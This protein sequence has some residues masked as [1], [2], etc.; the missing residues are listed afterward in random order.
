MSQRLKTVN[1]DAI[2]LVHRDISGEYD[3]GVVYGKFIS[4]NHGYSHG[5]W[6]KKGKAL[7][8]YGLEDESLL[9]MFCLVNFDEDIFNSVPVCEE[10]ENGKD[11]F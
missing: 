8:I 5:F 10:E 11:E 1:G 2:I 4:A 6:D 7:A 3:G 9:K